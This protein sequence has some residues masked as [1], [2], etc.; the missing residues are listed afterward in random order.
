MPVNSGI[1]LYVSHNHTWY[2]GRSHLEDQDQVNS[3]FTNMEES[4]MTMKSMLMLRAA[5]PIRI[6][7]ECFLST[8]KRRG[9]V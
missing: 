9:H 2:F 1:L 5:T 4:I 7:L 3:D 8:E 6:F